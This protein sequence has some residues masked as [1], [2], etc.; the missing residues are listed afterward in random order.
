MKIDLYARCWNESDMLPFFFLHYDKLVQRYIIYDDGSTDS[1]REIL[2]LNPKVELRPMP[3]YSDPESRIHSAL[4]LQET[5][6]KESRGSADWVI[7]TDIDEHLY[8]PQ[9]Y[10][11]L[12]HCRARGVTIIPA[13]G[14]QML[15]ERF[16][17]NKNLLCQSLTK[18]ACYSLYSKL[19]IFS[20]SEIEA[21]NYAPGRHTATPTGH[22]VLP[23]R[24]ELLLLHYH[25]LD[26]ERVRKRYAQF[27]TRQRKTDI[28]MGWG[29]QYSSSSKQLRTAWNGVADQ[30]VDISRPNLRPWKTHEG[31]RW[32]RKPAGLRKPLDLAK[33]CQT[34]V[35][36]MTRKFKNGR[37][38]ES[39]STLPL[40]REPES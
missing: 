22:V 1:S 9:M 27:L 12:A 23:T 10:Q 21:V 39:Q 8:H 35:R 32:W 14:Y 17:E 20:P 40:N 15:S 30:L 25:L 16:P 2:R 6:W 38:V 11:Y 29:G 13:L 37:S 26:F 34:R 33:R 19:N 28:A 36:A 24:D 5:C 4:A 31:P 3:P 7:V 18:G